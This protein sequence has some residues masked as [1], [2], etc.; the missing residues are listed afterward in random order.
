MAGAVQAVKAATAALKTLL[1]GGGDPSG[2]PVRCRLLTQAT[3]A[4]PV[5]TSPALE[6]LEAIQSALAYPQVAAKVGACC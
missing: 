3:A 6:A 5:E 1:S 4:L 2:G